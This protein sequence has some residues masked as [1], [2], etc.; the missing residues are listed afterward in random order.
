MILGCFSLKRVFKI[1]KDSGG[2]ENSF[3]QSSLTKTFSCQASIFLRLPQAA[4]APKLRIVP[5]NSTKSMN[6][7]QQTQEN[8]KGKSP[9]FI[10][11]KNKKAL[12][13]AFSLACLEIR[14][15]N[16]EAINSTQN[17]IYLLK[18]FYFLLYRC[19]YFLLFLNC[20]STHVSDDVCYWIFSSCRPQYFIS[21]TKS[22]QSIVT[23]HRLSFTQHTCKVSLGRPW[24]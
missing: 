23:W 5:K 14:S 11:Q 20:C 12:T 2:L 24:A 6:S 9:L 21:H 3:V 16:E 15:R 19:Q 18:V 10:L 4:Q 8:I 22:Q 1:Q 17:R 7:H 13:P